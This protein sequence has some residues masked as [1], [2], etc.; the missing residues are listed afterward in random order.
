MLKYTVILEPEDTGGFSA[1]CPSM[2]GCIA[3]GENKESAIENIKAAIL[4]AANAWQ[5]DDL[6]APEDSIDRIA[7]EIFE[8]LVS[9]QKENLS[10]TI[11]AVE[12]LVQSN[13]FSQSPLAENEM[14]PL[15]LTVQEDPAKGNIKPGALRA[16]IRHSGMSPEEF[17]NYIRAESNI[18][19]MII[20]KNI[21]L[22]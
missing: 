20:N 14:G 9:R 11:E 2:P 5:E 15:T 6:N 13:D 4:S 1:H 3:Q 10:L 8:I 7:D 17:M 12:V 16:L 18:V 19:Q 21:A 22:E